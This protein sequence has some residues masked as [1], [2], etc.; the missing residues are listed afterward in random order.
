MILL[1]LEIDRLADNRG[2][3]VAESVVGLSESETN[4]RVSGVNRSV[5]NISG[6]IRLNRT[7][8]T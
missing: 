3:I 5:I 7:E 4:G 6:K 1:R 2:V 8:T